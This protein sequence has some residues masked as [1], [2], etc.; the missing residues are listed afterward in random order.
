MKLA[1]ALSERSDI[2]K[3]LSQL[4]GRLDNNARVQ[5]G[6]EPSEDPQTLLKELDALVERLEVLVTQI[7]LTNAATKVGGE[8]LTAL[9]SRR[10]A[11][12]QKVSMMRD[13]LQEASSLA[14]R[15][16][17]SEIKIKSTVAVAELQKKVDKM[18]KDLRVLDEKI[19]EANWTT[20]LIE[21]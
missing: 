17:R 20:E 5:E 4:R 7:N 2:Q 9:L 14:G 15:A 21:P 6:E 13:F 12:Q 16:S 10:D 3:R 8:T 19:Q 11:L 18:S 1:T